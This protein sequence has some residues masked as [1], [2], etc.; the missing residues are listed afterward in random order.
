MEQKTILITGASGRLGTAF[1]RGVVASG[2]RVFLI[3]LD[4]EKGTLLAGAGASFYQ[5]FKNTIVL[6]I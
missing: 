5:I 2:C 1:A 6:T 3:D 4:E